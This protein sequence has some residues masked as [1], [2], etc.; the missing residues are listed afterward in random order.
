MLLCECKHS[1]WSCC[2]A[3]PRCLWLMLFC[4]RLCGLLTSALRSPGVSGQSSHCALHLTLR[5][6]CSFTLLEVLDKVK[7]GCVDWSRAHR[8][9]SADP[10]SLGQVPPGQKG[11]RGMYKKLENCHQAIEV[12]RRLNLS[13]VGIGSDHIV[14]GNKK[15]LLGTSTPLGLA[16]PSCLSC[17][18]AGLP[19]RSGRGLKSSGILEWTGEEKEAGGGY[20][21]FCGCQVEGSD[22][23]VRGPSAGT[24]AR[25]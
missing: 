23:Q 11:M 10:M 19:G 21:S 17:S 14:A 24:A 9:R 4:A 6:P 12:G 25:P 18:Q 22:Y 3:T 7:P 5:Y 8:L 1:P 13:L 16:P 2:L 20:S 15:F